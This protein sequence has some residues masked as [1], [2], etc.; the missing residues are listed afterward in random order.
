MQATRLW[1]G[2]YTTPRLRRRIMFWTITVLSFILLAGEWGAF[3]HY[4]KDNTTHGGGASAL[5]EA[6]GSL[7][8]SFEAA[9]VTV[10]INI[11]TRYGE[12]A[13]FA[14]E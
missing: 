14:R 11:A 2:M 6:L 13:P 3:V 8:F 4:R 10:G 5:L 7:P 1:I 12:H 9:S